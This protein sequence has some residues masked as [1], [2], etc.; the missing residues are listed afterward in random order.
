MTEK[1]LNHDL[2][3]LFRAYEAEAYKIPDP[4]QA[5]VLTASKRPFDGFARF[6]PPV[7]DFWFESKLIKNKISAFNSQRV[8]D[9]QFAALQ[10]IKQNGGHVAVILGCWIPRQDYWFMLFDVD[11]LLKRQGI[12]IK[13]K[14]L[15]ALCSQGYN[16]SLK[17][18]DADIFKP[19]WLVEK[20]ITALPGEDN[21]S[22]YR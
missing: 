7:N 4:G 12:S 19:E 10:H 22:L 11:F 5:T 9:H 8:E 17:N 14:D 18:K 2:I 1:N 21:G 6:P 13:Q 15:I 16:I 3:S 20:L